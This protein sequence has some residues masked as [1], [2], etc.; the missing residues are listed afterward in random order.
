MTEPDFNT[1][2]FFNCKPEKIIAPFKFG[3]DSA[4]PVKSKCFEN[5]LPLQ[6]PRLFPAVVI[7][8]LLFTRRLC[9]KTS[10]GWRGQEP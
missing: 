8:T 6:T 2:G 9:Q 7:R 3:T 5:H 1:L 10:Q 4:V